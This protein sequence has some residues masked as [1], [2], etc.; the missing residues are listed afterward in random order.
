MDDRAVRRKRRPLFIVSEV[1]AEWHLAFA[2]V[3]LYRGHLQLP[4][5][6]RG[7][8]V[9]GDGLLN[10]Y[11]G[12]RIEGSNPSVSASTLSSLNLKTSL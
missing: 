12:N 8:V 9:D 4:I 6:R 3:R 1:P 11:T 10:H 7:R 5:W 2:E